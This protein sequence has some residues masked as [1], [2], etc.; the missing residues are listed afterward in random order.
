MDWIVLTETTDE[1]SMRLKDLAEG[2]QSNSSAR[3]F[4]LVPA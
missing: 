1:S 4:E 3:G 2:C